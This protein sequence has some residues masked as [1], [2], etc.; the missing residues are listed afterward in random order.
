MK[1]KIKLKL[2]LIALFGVVMMGFK[3]DA[4][5]GQVV[6]FGDSITFGAKVDGK[7]WVY[8]LNQE[9]PDVE[10]VNAGRSGRKTSDKNELLPVLAKYPNADSYLIFLGVN[11]LKDGTNAMV[12]DCVENMKWMIDE[13]K[14]VNSKAQ[15]VILSPTDINTKTMAEVNVKKKYNENTRR[16][17][18]LLKK[19]Y[20]ALAKEENVGFYSLLNAVS[21]PNYADGL[22][23]DA[24]GQQQIAKSVWRGLN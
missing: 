5:N 9:H 6:C 15:I 19:R 7:S 22:H 16:C 23:P 12:D 11:D 20:A 17:L 18:K 24:A 3:S 21:K 2:G 10:F 13:I 8:Y 4:L 1:T 14:K